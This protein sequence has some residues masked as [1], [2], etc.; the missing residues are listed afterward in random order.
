M[1]NLIIREARKN[2]DEMNNIKTF[3][4]NQI[5]K[6]YG[7]GP[8]P[9]FHYD[10]DGLDEYYLFPSKN[11]FFIAL[12]G[13]EIVATAGIR[14]YDVDYDFFNGVY[15]KDDTAS[16]WRV[17]VDEAYRRHG[18]ANKLVNILEK[19]AKMEG[20]ERIYL[21][22]YGYLEEGLQFWKSMGYEVTIEE[23][24]YDEITHMIKNL[25]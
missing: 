2:S 12:D 4:Y 16:I 9:R 20:Y 7:I 5:K 19:F 17:M 1:V 8:T 23:D 15:S 6:E 13:G 14:A 22:T 24:D 21:Q 18:I 11:T 25:I 3:L 10:I